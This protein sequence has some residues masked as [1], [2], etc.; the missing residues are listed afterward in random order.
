MTEVHFYKIDSGE[1]PVE[2]FLN[3]LTGK[4]AQ[5]IV[6]ILQL[7]KETPIPPIQYFQKLPNTDDIWE[8]GV[9]LG[10]DILRIL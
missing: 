8:I 3:A 9:H 10:N 7:L 2:N 4:Q 6:W 5:K 1:C